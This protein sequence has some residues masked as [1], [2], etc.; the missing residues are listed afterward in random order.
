M[1]S[2]LDSFDSVASVGVSSDIFK[3]TLHSHFHSCAAINKHIIDMFFQA[4]I[5]SRFN[6]DT[7]ALSFALFRVSDSFLD[8][9]WAMAR[10]GV[11]QISNEV[12]SILLIK[13]HESATHHDEFN[14]VCLM[15]QSFELFNSIFCLQIRVVSGSNSP[16][17]C[18]FIPCVT[19]SGILKV[20]V[21]PSRA[22]NA[23]VTCHSNVRASMR[24]THDGNNR[25]TR[26]SPDWLSF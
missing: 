13:T 14:F 6:S 8:C 16:H 4:I 3:N 9:G 19:L 24:L 2:L 20:W 21:R 17:R 25:H 1:E 18:W 15:A 26:G 22:I 11:M 7:D 12:I 5:W 10:K 23:N